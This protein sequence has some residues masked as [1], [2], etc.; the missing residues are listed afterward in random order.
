VN[1]ELL[2]RPEHVTHASVGEVLMMKGELTAQRA[3][4]HRSPPIIADRN[5]RVVLV[6]SST[7][8]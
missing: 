2:R 5:V 4:V 3:I 8:K 1:D 7:T 6:I